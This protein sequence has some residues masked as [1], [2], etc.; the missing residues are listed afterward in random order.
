MDRL[1]TMVPKIATDEPE[2]DDPDPA[3]IM[4]DA[5]VA[6]APR[7]PALTARAGAGGTPPAARRT[8]RRHAKRRYSTSR[9]ADATRGADRS[10]RAAFTDPHS[11]PR[12]R[13]GRRVPRPSGT[14]DTLAHGAIRFRG[15]D[16][17]RAV[18]RGYANRGTRGHVRCQARSRDAGHLLALDRPCG[19][20]RTGG[21]HH[22]AAKTSR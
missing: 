19:R 2:R 15:K 20:S 7:P 22:S 14:G 12:S 8:K 21:A 16:L 1:R 4:P 18:G 11:L 10:S 13:P 9:L 3:A 5:S 6:L 17:C